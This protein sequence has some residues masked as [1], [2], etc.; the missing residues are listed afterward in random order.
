MVCDSDVHPS[1]GFSFRVKV[2][3]RCRRL[4]YA[5]Q[6][7]LG[8]IFFAYLTISCGSFLLLSKSNLE[9][10]PS[11]VEI[12]TILA[13]MVV[14]V[15]IAWLLPLFTRVAFK[16]LRGS[17]QSSSH[18]IDFPNVEE[19]E[20][21]FGC[22]GHSADLSRLH[23]Q[24]SSPSNIP[25]ACTASRIVITP[26]WEIAL[27]SVPVLMMLLVILEIRYNMF[28]GMALILLGLSAIC[29]S[30]L[31]GTTYRI[32]GGNLVF[33]HRTLLPGRTESGK[34]IDLRQALV[35]CSFKDMLLE[36]YTKDDGVINVPLDNITRSRDVVVAVA[37]VAVS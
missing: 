17:K 4:F 15:Y 30:A 13:F 26:Q 9:Q 5:R 27:R 8:P 11:I 36:I 12:I 3:G 14:I 37:R 6:W 24:L 10:R 20:C 16:V 21:R 35:T 2:I 7:L 28:F 34:T 23:D 32:E 18:P 33:N 29:F 31:C 25:M 22:I 1:V 19:H